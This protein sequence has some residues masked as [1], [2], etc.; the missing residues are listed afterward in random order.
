MISQTLPAPAQSLLTL[1]GFTWAD[2]LTHCSGKIDE[3]SLK[4]MLA[5]MDKAIVQW[6]GKFMKFEP[7]KGNTGPRV[8]VIQFPTYREIGAEYVDHNIEFDDNT[9]S[10]YG[11]FFQQNANVSVNLLISVFDNGNYKLCLLRN[12][13]SVKPDMSLTFPLFAQLVLTLGRSDADLYFDRVFKGMRIPVTG[14]VKDLNKMYTECEDGGQKYQGSFLLQVMSSLSPNTGEY[15]DIE[16]LLPQ[17]AS[18]Y[19][20]EIRERFSSKQ[21]GQYLLWEAHGIFR[22]RGSKKDPHRLELASI[23]FINYIDNDQMQYIGHLIPAPVQQPVVRVSPPPATNP[24]LPFGTSSIQPQIAPPLPLPQLQTNP[25]GAV[26]PQGG[27]I[28]QGGQYQQTGQF[29]QGGQYQQTGQFQQGGQ[30][31][32]T[33][34]FQ[35]GGQYQQTGQFQQGG[36]YQQTGQFQQGGQY[37]QTGQFQQGGVTGPQYG[38]T[39]SQYGVTGSQYGATGQQYGV[40]GQQYGATGVPFGATGM[41]PQA[42]FPGPSNYNQ[43]YKPNEY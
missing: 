3:Q 8:M 26:G 10:T 30:Y 7:Q 22:T 12:D 14:V 35:Q 15:D 29:Q 38:V 21:D 2:Y 18:K 20:D 1:P 19:I 41:Q 24:T 4:P 25:Y 6:L 32:Q 42:Q 5:Q 17:N 36:Q 11:N 39:G 13:N 28:Q 23:Y 27:Q 40:T 16:F 37:Q 31:Q 33:G 43:Q 9:L 34:Q